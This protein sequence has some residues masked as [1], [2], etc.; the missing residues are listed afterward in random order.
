[1]AHT[2]NKFNLRLILHA[3]FPLL[4]L[5]CFIYWGNMVVALDSK[6]IC[7]YLQWLVEYI[8]WIPQQLLTLWVIK[9]PCTNWSYKG[10]LWIKQKHI[11]NNAN[12]NGSESNYTHKQKKKKS[13]QLP[14][15]WWFGFSATT[16]F[17]CQPRSNLMVSTHLPVKLYISA[18]KTNTSYPLPLYIQPT[19]QAC[20]LFSANH[21][22]RMRPVFRMVLHVCM[23]ILR[24]KE[25]K[26][27]KPI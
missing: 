11:I 3:P 14:P 16:D 1:M 22:I 6:Y 13:V 7:N 17:I 5:F 15:E 26:E 10:W 2:F 12:K 4:L 25:G 20:I 21:G 23:L 9:S 19:P 18:Q 8:V 27:W 24:G